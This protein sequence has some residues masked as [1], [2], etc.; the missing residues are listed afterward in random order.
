[1]TQ[2]LCQNIKDYKNPPGTIK[3]NDSLFIDVAPVD[4]LMYLEYFQNHERLSTKKMDIFLKNSKNYGINRK[5]FYPVIEDLDYFKFRV[6]NILNYSQ[7]PKFQ[8]YPAIEITKTEA[9]SYC[10]WRTKAVLLNYAIISKT[11]KDRMKYAKK[12][13]YRLPTKDEFLKAVEVFGYLK[14]PVKG[15]D[16]IPFSPYRLR[17]KRKYKRSLFLKNNLSEYTIDSL[18]FGNNWRNKTTFKDPNDY[19]GFRCVCEIIE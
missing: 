15:D 2:V 1:M 13:I 9:E 19:T 10:E 3:L 8:R 17:Y 4:N 7:H 5:P 18:P 12:L 11:A 6:S 14:K 16:S